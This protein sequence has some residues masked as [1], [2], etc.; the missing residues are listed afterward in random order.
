MLVTLVVANPMLFALAAR[1]ADRLRRQDVG[2]QIVLRGSATRLLDDPGLQ[3][4]PFLFGSAV[5]AIDAAKNL[6]RV[7]QDKPA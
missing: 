5:E 4:Q 1:A 7:K 6:L 3:A 2:A